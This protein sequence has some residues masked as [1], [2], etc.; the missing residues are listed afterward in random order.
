MVGPLGTLVAGDAAAVVYT[1]LLKASE[2]RAE[3]CCVRGRV[4][5]D[6]RGAQDAYGNAVLSAAFG[7]QAKG[8]GNA[9]ADN[10]PC[11][12]TNNNN[13]NYTVRCRATAAA[14]GVRRTAGEVWRQHAWRARR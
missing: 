12:V 3:R 13:G 14:R 2:W 1:V 7:A 5:G 10:G 8:Q 9:A 6:E 11:Q 4:A